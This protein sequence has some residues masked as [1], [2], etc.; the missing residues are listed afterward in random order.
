RS[1]PK[2]SDGGRTYTLFLRPGLEYSDGTPVRASDFE[3]TI[4]RL[5]RINSPGA[6]LYT[7]IAGAERFSK[8][9]DGNIGGIET[10]ERT[11]KIVI[12]LVEPRSSFSN[13]LADLF[14]A[15][16]PADT[17]A[18]NQT[19]SPPPATGPYEITSSEPGI[20]WEYRRNPAWARSN[21]AAMPE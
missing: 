9:K 16:L 19:K 8:A 2:L 10:D 11:G 7:E 1:L 14:A 4:E 21:S 12:H 3:T 13:L 17:P 5:F 18:S 15:P 20:C 6:P